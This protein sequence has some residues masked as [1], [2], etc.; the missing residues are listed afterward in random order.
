MSEENLI[1]ENP[2]QASIS[3]NPADLNWLDTNEWKN[4]EFPAEKGEDDKIKEIKTRIEMYLDGC[5]AMYNQT[6]EPKPAPE[7]R[8]TRVRFDMVKE[9]PLTFAVQAFLTPFVVKRRDGDPESG[10]SHLV[11]QEPPDPDTLG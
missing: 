2:T 8:V 7:F 3:D 5:I 9:S 11:P 6:K 10:G 1:K 4:L